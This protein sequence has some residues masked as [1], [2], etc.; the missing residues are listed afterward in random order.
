MKDSPMSQVTIRRLRKED[1]ADV[2]RIYEAITKRSEKLD[3]RWIVEDR[4]EESL[5]ASFVAEFEGKVVGY[6]ISY[7][8]SGN[9][10]VDRCAWIS[11]FGVEPKFMGG[12]IGRRLA[13][14]IFRFY[15]E[16]NVSDVFTSVRWDYTDILSFFK[17]LGFNRSEFLHLHKVLR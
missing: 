11:M 12:G 3:I 13:G 10:G 7:I 1:A 16:N 4:A 6:M 14:E 5:D 17:T 2:K 15:K 8:T 9:F